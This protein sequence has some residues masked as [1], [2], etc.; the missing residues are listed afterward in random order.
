MQSNSKH[1]SEAVREC[2]QANVPYVIITILGAKGSTP[3]DSGT[4]MVV[5]R[6]SFSGTIGGGVLEMS[7]LQ[8]AIV[9][10]D[11]KE[12]GQWVEHYPL[13]EKLG[14]CCGGATSLLFEAFQPQTFNVLLFGA[15]HVGRAL[16]PILGSLPLRVT[17]V[18]SRAAEFPEEIPSGLH[19]AQPE[20]PIDVVSAA[21]PGSYFLI[22]THK[23][24]LDYA[25][26]E[27]A[28]RRGDA[29][30]IGIIGSSSKAKR[31]ALRLAHR[32]YSDSA[33][34][35]IHCPIGDPKVPGKRP[36]EIAV[37][38]AAQL[39]AHYSSEA[40]RV[41]GADSISFANPTCEGVEAVAQAATKVSD[42]SW[43]RLSQEL[44]TAGVEALPFEATAHSKD[45][46]AKTGTHHDD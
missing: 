21:K 36:A 16:A 35:S 7:A 9:L 33:I 12:T 28:L 2:E 42:V 14:Q 34:R 32:G 27:A 41:S 15:G 3:R 1:W 39:I 45:K 18:D 26:G 25:L 4:K 6:E 22:M 43:K 38:I 20:D 24:P 30:Y 23:H 5:Q 10:M 40:Q 11:A 44:S 31:F 17:W 8:R 19:T 13:G 37:S 29:A 46:A